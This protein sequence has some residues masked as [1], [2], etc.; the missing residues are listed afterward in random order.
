MENWAKRLKE[1]DLN[2]FKA[3]ILNWFEPIISLL[4]GKTLSSIW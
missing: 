3:R 4:S 1:I 2:P